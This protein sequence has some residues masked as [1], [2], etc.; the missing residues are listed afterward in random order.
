MRFSF[1]LAL[2]L[3]F[4]CSCAQSA[5]LESKYIVNEVLSKVLRPF[6]TTYTEEDK[7]VIKYC[8]ETPCELIKSDASVNRDIVFDFAL[9]FYLFDT[10]YQEFNDEKYKIPSGYN[11]YSELTKL[12]PSVADKYKLVSLCQD[13][14]EMEMC[15][16]KYLKDKYKIETTLIV[17]SG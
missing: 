10:S 1:L 2:S 8:P 15:I 14:Y 17:E 9:L 5:Q 3:F 11:P 12:V 7:F 4:Q 13:D 6:F 16:L